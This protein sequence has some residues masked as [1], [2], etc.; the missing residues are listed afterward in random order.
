MSEVLKVTLERIPYMALFI[1]LIPIG[2]MYLSLV[3]PLSALSLQM[4]LLVLAGLWG[5]LGV[6]R[7]FM[8]V[9]Y[10]G[11][12]TSPDV[13][14]TDVF[15]VLMAWNSALLRAI[16]EGWER[17]FVALFAAYTLGVI[18]SFFIRGATTTVV[19]F[20][21]KCFLKRKER[22]WQRR[23]TIED[24]KYRVKLAVYKE[25]SSIRRSV[26]FELIYVCLLYT[27][28]SPRDRG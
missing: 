16:T 4:L 1:A 19:E 28:P 20:V 15:F 9:D 8:L 10:L 2:A 12:G 24:I 5:E 17:V 18:H 22:E 13:L 27:S 14:T 26:A 6:P 7:T 23:L 21:R 3:L 25:V 11:A